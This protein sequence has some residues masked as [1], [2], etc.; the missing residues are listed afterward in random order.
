[1]TTTWRPRTRTRHGY[2]IPAP[3]TTSNGWQPSSAIRRAENAVHERRLAR[4]YVRLQAGTLVIWDRAPWQ[5]IAVNERPED[6]WDAKYEASFA[7]TLK[8]WEKRGVGTKPE[9]STWR[10]RPMVVQIVPVADPRAE[11][12]HL[13]APG[14]HQ[15]TV[16]TEHYSVC[17]ACGELP[18][19]SHELAEQEADIIAARNDVLMDIPPGHCLGCG[20]FVTHRQKAARFPGPNLWRPD[21][22]EHSAVFHARQEC[23][24]E[25]ER[26]RRQ[27]EE[28]GGSTP[29]TQLSLDEES[30]S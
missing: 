20:E 14:N 17:V 1:M 9:R 3:E 10:G 18:P 30:A 16:L 21:L 29:Q 4:Q 13:V 8:H 2:T 6:L 5:V 23:A 26:Y 7:S 11:P 28:R 25:V 24:G 15:W 22:P 27:W 19:C 12:L